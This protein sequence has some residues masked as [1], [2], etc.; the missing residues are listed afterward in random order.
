MAAVALSFPITHCRLWE[1]K[2]WRTIGTNGFCTKPHD[3]CSL[4]SLHLIP[5]FFCLI[6][7]YSLSSPLLCFYQLCI[8]V[9]LSDPTTWCCTTASSVFPSWH[10]HYIHTD[11]V[12]AKVLF[13]FLYLFLLSLPTPGPPAVV[14]TGTHFSSIPR[15][16]LYTATAKQ[17]PGTLWSK[18]PASCAVAPSVD[19]LS[20]EQS[21]PLPSS[22][23][24][25][26]C[27]PGICIA[28]DGFRQTGAMC[29]NNGWA[30]F[31]NRSVRFTSASLGST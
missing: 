12:L 10:W 27:P 11:I 31:S 4:G 16:F 14:S 29:W 3:G 19:S 21:V 25:S 22:A 24:F 26:S 23:S 5:S 18:Q 6:L 15:S 30:A 9:W 7:S 8:C 1:N 13:P 20:R 28:L 17:T 2:L